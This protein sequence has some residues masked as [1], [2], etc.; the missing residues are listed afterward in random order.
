MCVKAAFLRLNEC[1]GFHAAGACVQPRVLRLQLIN[2]SMY[3]L[4]K[5]GFLHHDSTPATCQVCEE[6]LQGYHELLQRVSRTS[7]MSSGSQLNPKVTQVLTLY[8]KKRKCIGRQ[9]E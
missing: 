2:R 5:P 3:V 6:F 4:K 1:G 7:R 8:G 9:M